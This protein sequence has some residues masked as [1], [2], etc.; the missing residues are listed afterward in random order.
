MHT[1]KYNW[2]I[3]VF[4]ALLV[5]SGCSPA[6][7]VSQIS[8]TI[9]TP[10][11]APVTGAGLIINDVIAQTNAK[12]QFTLSTTAGRHKALILAK[13]CAPAILELDLSA[14]SQALTLK[15]N[16]LKPTK[17]TGQKI[18]YLV[19][20][21]PQEKTDL[22]AASPFTY[23]DT[24]GIQPA[25]VTHAGIIDLKQAVEYL[26][27]KAL[28]SLCSILNT[29][30]IVWINKDLAD[31]LQIFDS[32]T[33]LT[34]NVPFMKG[35]KNQRT[36]NKINDL[37]VRDWRGE[38]LPLD[39]S[40][41]ATEARLAQE[42]TDYME[43]KYKITYAGHDVQRVKQIANS[44]IAVSERPSLRF[45]FGILETTEYNAY[46]LPGG[47]IYIT[48]PLYDML[49]GDDELAAVLSHEIAHITHIHAVKSY[50]RQ[51]ALLV[52]GVLLAVAI[53][54]STAFDFVDIISG[55]VRQGYSKEQELDAD[56]TG[57]RYLA[58]A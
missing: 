56:K 41:K 12:G 38:A 52:A 11:G 20:I 15:A 42:V 25:A 1:R 58:K 50:E 10:T 53:G 44:V 30:K 13:G 17:R 32:E 2:L 3:L 49:E 33:Q 46:A 39:V 8:G 28:Q 21:D 37:L 45:T 4:L 54:D 23:F 9:I 29:R 43:S 35:K 7:K 48:R 40:P 16:P 19:L 14:G 6:P 31:H 22:G 55:I 57:L 24:S 18:D 34:Y 51:T 5:I 36:V 27:P 47:Y 26:S